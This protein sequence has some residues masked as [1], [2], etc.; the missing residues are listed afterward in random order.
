MRLST[1]GRYGLK[2]IISIGANEENG[3]VSLKYVA[4]SEGISE[5]YLEQLVALLKKGGLIV[6]TRGAKGGY[7]L[8]K[9]PNELIVGNILKVLEGSINVVE[10]IS[11]DGKCECNAINSC[12][13]KLVWEKVTEAINNVVNNMTLKELIDDYKEGRS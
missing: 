10:C 11:D 1:K 3:P 8:A 5:A 4:E 13:T 9:E 6:S 2:A 7:K 12:S